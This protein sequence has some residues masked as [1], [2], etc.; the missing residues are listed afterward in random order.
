MHYVR[1]YICV[2]L[3]ICVRLDMHVEP[4]VY[5]SALH[6]C[7]QVERFWSLIDVLADRGRC[8]VT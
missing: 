5:A 1:L 6:S 2:C 7:P 3:C 8:A 4:S